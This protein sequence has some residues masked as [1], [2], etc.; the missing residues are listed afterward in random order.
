MRVEWS[1]GHDRGFIFVVIHMW[2]DKCRELGEVRET[3]VPKI[4]TNHQGSQAQKFSVLPILYLFSYSWHDCWGVVAFWM[5]VLHYIILLWLLLQ[6]LHK[7]SSIHTVLEARST[8][9]VS[10]VSRAGPSGSLR[11]NPCFAS[12][13][14]WCLLASSASG[15]SR[16]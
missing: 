3:T 15:S 4:A 13:S 5:W 8:I 6:I 14:A 12:L 7:L 9:S 16:H 10:R 1:H 11:K 2:E